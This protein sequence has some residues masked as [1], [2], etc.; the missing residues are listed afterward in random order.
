MA[1]TAA[2]VILVTTKYLFILRI[3]RKPHLHAHQVPLPIEGC[4]LGY[5]MHLPH[6]RDV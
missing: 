6:S 2:M 5:V 1:I 3:K 4:L